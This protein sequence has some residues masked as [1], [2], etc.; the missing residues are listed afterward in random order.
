MDYN[1]ASL[2]HHEHVISKKCQQETDMSLTYH[3]H[4]ILMFY[5]PPTL[6]P[7]ISRSSMAKRS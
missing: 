3:H 5:K 4:E 7:C 1:Q 2:T 6:G